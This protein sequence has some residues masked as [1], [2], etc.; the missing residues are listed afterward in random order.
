M[1]INDYQQAALRTADK[2]RLSDKEM[3]TNGVLGL[4]GESGECA[5]IV[6]K[7]LFQ[8][9]ELDA[10]KLANELGDVAWYLAVTAKAIGL[11]LET[12]LQMNV[13]KLYKRYPDGFSAE[14]SIHREEEQ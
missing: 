13:D 3:L 6:K 14:R 8:G 1:T 5:D 10:D 7:H 2:G 11:D 4:S 9:H 12:V